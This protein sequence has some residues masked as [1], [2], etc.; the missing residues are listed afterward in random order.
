MPQ[1]KK[2]KRSTQQPAPEVLLRDI[3]T[4]ATMMGTTTFAVRELCRSGQLKYI[5]IGHRWLIS[6]SAMQAFIT[7]AEKAAAA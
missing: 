5:S 4:T 3:P 1:Q 7:R 6:T 2:Q